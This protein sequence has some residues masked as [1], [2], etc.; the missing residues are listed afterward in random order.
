MPLDD[1]TAITVGPVRVWDE[2]SGAS[3]LNREGSSAW[4]KVRCLWAD[5][6]NLIPFVLG[7]ATNVAGSVQYQL[8]K[9]WGDWQSLVATR[10]DVTGDGLL[11]VGASGTIAYQWAVVKF[12]FEPPTWATGNPSAIGDDELETCTTGVC[13]S[14]DHP[15]F[16]YLDGTAIDAGMVPALELTTVI[17]NKTRDFVPVLPIDLVSSL[18]DHVNSV[19]IFGAPAEFIKFKGARSR[20]SVFY[21]GPTQWSVTATFERASPLTIGGWNYLPRP[22]TGTWERFR[23]I[24]GGNPL[25]PLANLGALFAT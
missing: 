11:S 14:S 20:R 22:S 5:Q 24:V 1:S 18:V 16:E 23:T 19:A 3:L 10:A 7:G 15:S 21:N 6:Y 13:L 4:W 25:F 9:R 12:T 8:P 2:G 17:F